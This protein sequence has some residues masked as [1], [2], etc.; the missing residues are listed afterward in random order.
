MR[1]P[2]VL[3][4]GLLSVRVYAGDLL[5]PADALFTEPETYSYTLSPD[6]RLVVGHLNLEGHQKSILVDTST[7]QHYLLLDF[8]P[9]IHVRQYEWIDNDTLF[10]RFGEARS[11]LETLAFVDIRFV[12]DMP[13]TTIKRVAARGVLIDPMQTVEDTVLFAREPYSGKSKYRLYTITVDQLRDSAFKDARAFKNSLTDAVMY[14]MDR[15]SRHLLA[16]SYRDGLVQHWYLDGSRNR[17]VRLFEHDPKQYDFFLI[18]KLAGNRFAALTNKN[19]DRISLVEFGPEEEKIGAVLYQHPRYDLTDAEVDGKKGVVRSV[20]YVDHG[21]TV[22][23][24][25]AEADSRIS[26]LLRKAFPRKHVQLMSGGN[27]STKRILYVSASDDPGTFYLLDT[28][29]GRAEILTPRSPVTETYELSKSDVFSVSTADGEQIEAIITR[30]ARPNG[31][32][33]V[34]PHG[35]PVG[36]RDYAAYDPEVQ[37]FASRGYSVLSVNFR[38][39]SGFGREFL[40]TGRGE[41]GKRIEEDI[42]AAVAEV[43]SQHK[44]RKLCA[45]GSSYGGYSAMMLAIRRPGLYRCAVSMFG[46]SDLPFVF[47]TTNYTLLEGPQKALESVIGDYSDALKDVSP[48]YLAERL[49]APVLL[50]AGTDDAIADYEQTNRMKYRLQQLGKP[51]EYY[52]YANT[53]HGHHYWTGDRHQFALIDD[54]IRRKLGLEPPAAENAAEVLGAEYTLIGDFYQDTQLVDGNVELAARYYEKAAQ[55]NDARGLYKLASLHEYGTGVARDLE[56]AH[57]YLLQ[58]SEHG[59]PD[60]TY[61]LARLY[62]DGESGELSRAADPARSFELFQK[63]KEQGHAL[64]R[65]DIA[66][67][68]CTGAGV[69]PNIPECLALLAFDRQDKEGAD[70]GAKTDRRIDVFGA[71]AWSE[72]P[73]PGARAEISAFIGSALDARYAGIEELEIKES[74]LFRDGRMRDEDIP[75]RKGVKFGVGFRVDMERGEASGDGRFVVKLRLT[76]P[77]AADGGDRILEEVIHVGNREEMSRLTYTIVDERERVAGDWNL[78][79]R[80]LD[81]RLLADVDFH[82]G[83]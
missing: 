13:E 74:G 32:L 68:L 61:R 31:V 29:T 63:A 38:G 28:S 6:S 60:A 25:F 75:A 66:Q 21:R 22:T 59:Y 18:G 56:L 16:A 64:A 76:G 80:A 15:S 20:S 54:F 24:Y 36:V 69:E 77:A 43:M 49:Q 39:S 7:L 79:I 55:L 35:G 37:F 40:D 1:V 81:H 53:G 82:V 78:E 10:L 65:L 33:L 51:V 11:V 4:A 50:I 71:L 52:Y 27:G 47:N 30:P 48:F 9:G 41:F 73:V 19:T 23:E 17:W 42:S 45:I 12:N 57:D 34:K 3:L 46:L 44:F 62:R 58:A 70:F 83:G 26:Q 72:P 14:R 67:A 8:K 5:I 2:T